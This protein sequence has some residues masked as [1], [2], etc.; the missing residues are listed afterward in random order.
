MPVIGQTLGEGMPSMKT[1]LSI[2]TISNI[3][4]NPLRLDIEETDRSHWK[5]LFD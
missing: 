3:Y 1:D 2:A 4:G 5:L